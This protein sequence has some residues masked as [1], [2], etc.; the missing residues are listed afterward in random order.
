MYQEMEESAE[1]YNKNYYRDRRQHKTIKRAGAYHGI[2]KRDKKYLKIEQR[3]EKNLET[4]EI[5][6]TNHKTKERANK[7]IEPIKKHE[8]SM[9]DVKKKGKL[10]GAEE[11]TGQP[12]DIEMWGCND[13]P[14]D[15]IECEILEE[16]S[17]KEAID[18][19]FKEEQVLNPSND[20]LNKVLFEKCTH[21]C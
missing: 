11:N 12:L 4:L 10:L 3:A 13:D 6:E 19:P 17:K 5:D 18:Q 9:K 15:I 8:T 16:T 20:I 1:T 2:K 21:K 7:I 14:L